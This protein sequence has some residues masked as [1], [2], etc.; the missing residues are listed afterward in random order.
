MGAKLGFDQ[1]KADDIE[2]IRNFEATLAD[3]KPD[4]T[5]FYQLL[6][7]FPV[8]IQG[9]DEIIKYFSESYYME[10]V[11]TQRESFAAV[12]Q[13]YTERIKQN[14]ISQEEKKRKMTESN[15]RFVL[16]NY[17]LHQAIQGLEK[18]E[19]TLFM[20]LQEAIKQPYSTSANEF[21]TKRPDWAS[22]QAGCSML[23]CSS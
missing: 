20:K 7:N 22:Q 15:P 19:N 23:S 6:I 3:I 2:L 14:N 5:I 12:M 1:L 13:K 16:R 18:G 11:K 10:P 8:D 21:F 9:E 17:L 4:M